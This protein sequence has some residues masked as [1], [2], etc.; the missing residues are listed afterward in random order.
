M[1]P[2]PLAL[3]ATLWALAPALW[4]QA[5]GSAGFAVLDVNEATRPFVS[6]PISGFSQTPDGVLVV[7]SDRLAT[8]D[9]ETWRSIDIPG[10]DHFYA[11]ASAFDGKRVWITAN[12][13]LG[14]IERS[15]AGNWEFTSLRPAL[16][17]DH[18]ADFDEIRQVQATAAGAIFVGRSQVI[19]WDGTHFQAWP[20]PS[21]MRLYASPEGSELY[22]HQVGVGLLRFDADGPRLQIGDADLPGVAP[23]VAWLRLRDGRRLVVTHEEVFVR[24]G[25]RWQRL[26]AATQLLRGR[27]ALHAAVLANGTI[28]VGTS[29]GGLI[30]LRSDGQPLGLIDPSHGLRSNDVTA[31]AADSTGRLWIGTSIGL[32]RLSGGGWASLFDQRARLSTRDVQRMI[33]HDEGVVEAVTSLGLYRFHP[34]QGYQAAQ[35]G[36]ETGA[37]LP[38]HSAVLVDGQL[39]TAGPLGIA[40]SEGPA[41]ILQ[42]QEPNHVYF[43]QALSALAHGF[44][45]SDATSFKA[46]TKNASG[47]WEG[48]RLQTLGSI[49]LTAAEDRRGDLWVATL[50]GTIQNFRWDP[51]AQ[52]LVPL[53]TFRHEGALAELGSHPRVISALHDL[54][55]LGELGVLRY[56]DQEQRFESVAEFRGLKVAGTVDCA[57]GAYWAVSRPELGP[58]AP[59]G[60]LRLN[61]ESAASGTLTLVPLF[62][63]GL[64][65]IGRIQ[66]LDLTREDNR[67]ILWVIGSSAVLRFDG[68]S[69]APADPVPAL[70]LQGIRLDENRYRP[71]EA[72]RPDFPAGIRHI[73]IELSAGAA[74]QDAGLRF[75]SRLEGKERDWSPPRAAASVELARLASGSY[76]LQARAVDRFGRTGPV[77]DYPFLLAAPWYNRPA[78]WASWIILAA[79]ILAGAV[80]ARFRS[81]EKQAARLNQ[82]VDDRTREL[83]LSN[84]AKSEFLDTISHEI[85]DPLNGIVGLVGVLS[86][87]GLTPEQREQTAALRQCSLSLIRMVSEVLNLSRL[88]YGPIRLEESPFLLADLVRSICSLQALSAQR[89]GCVLTVRTAEDFVDG[90]RGDQGKI[91]TILNNFVG[92]GLKYAPGFPI[93]IS[94]SHYE[95]TP[96]SGETPSCEVL[97]EVA[98]HGPGVPEAEQELIFKKFVRGSRVKESAVPG[99]GMGLATCRVMAQHLGGNV[100]IENGPEDGAIFSLT[101]PLRRQAVP[102]PAPAAPAMRFGGVA[103]IVDD[104]HYNRVVMTGLAR[105]LGFEPLTAS[106]AKEALAV[107]ERTVPTAILIDVEL[108][109]TRGPELARRIRSRPAGAEPLILATSADDR[110]STRRECQQAGMDGFLVKPVERRALESVLL[111]ATEHRRP[112]EPSDPALDWSALELYDQAGLR[113]LP[114]ARAAYCSALQAEMSALE[115]ALRGARPSQIG[116]AAHRLRSHAALVKATDLSHL[117]AELEHAARSRR[118]GR[119]GPLWKAIVAAAAA[120]E[121]QITGPA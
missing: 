87:S 98:D 86:E 56:N 96:S 85:R 101:V 58:N 84:A 61:S 69:L 73:F 45:Y 22:I 119:V 31:L 114:D 43:T 106:N 44:I 60:L 15:A 9:G 67:E 110:P 48:R 100:S 8:F 117:A 76:L 64:D 53:R 34:G 79:M 90:F 52:K 19:R 16:D 39:W 104:Q 24:S 51:A 97:I 107:L 72:A 116:Q 99:V 93:E 121:A 91:R 20:L 92:N 37:P 7:S 10:I 78:A 54:W 38:L 49:P 62:A 59:G 26:E 17:A 112:A 55:A 63:P 50:E 88:E 68:Q 102:P 36:R 25:D 95:S 40:L 94:I 89:Q 57:G 83:S 23:I 29:Y 2:R 108:P 13:R 118:L 14:Y 74:T 33:E 103:L 5:P 18:I 105:S 3:L 11:S 120:V 81:L 21:P 47:H 71:L 75:Q 46:W 1:V 30:L 35:F 41:S 4:G 28:A 42:P 115:A 80:R 66:R 12:D 113:D 111:S 82:L 27:R 70:Q 6:G 32:T 109:G 65:Q 77:F